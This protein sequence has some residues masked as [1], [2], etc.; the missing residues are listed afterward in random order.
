MNHI[1]LACYIVAIYILW[2]AINQVMHGVHFAVLR[3]YLAGLNNAA[4][5]LLSTHTKLAKTRANTSARFHAKNQYAHAI[6]EAETAL[7]QNLLN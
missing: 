5:R 7:G 2:C 1:R 4:S 6:I 3:L